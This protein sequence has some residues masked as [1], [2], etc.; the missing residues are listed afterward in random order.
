MR[1]VFAT[2]HVRPSAQA[3]PLAAGCLVAALPEET[4]RDA[5]LVDLFPSQSL[6]EMAEAVLDAA[7][8]LVA[9]PVYVWNRDRLLALAALLRRRQPA[10]RIIAGGP[11]AGAAPLALLAPGTIDLL[12]QGEAEDI[13]PQ[14]LTLS[15]DTAQPPPGVARFDGGQLQS[16]PAAP[17]PEV[18]KLNSPWLSGVLTPPADGGLLWETSRGCPF[19]CDFCFDSRGSNRVRPLPWE[20]LEAELALFVRARV[21]QIW[22]LDSTFNYPPERGKK[23]LRLLA[24]KAPHIHFH[25][26]AKADFLDRETAHLLGALSCS[27]QI[28]LQSAHP[29]VLRTIHRNLDPD[30]FRKNI[31]LL[32]AEGVTYGLDL[33]YGLPGDSL[34]GFGASL[35]FALEQRPNQIDIFP[36]AVLPGTILHRERERLGLD[37]QPAPPYEILAAPGFPADDLQQACLLA[38]VTDIFY[39]RGRAVGFF[40]PLQRGAGLGALALLEEFLRWLRADKALGEAAIRD[41]EAWLPRAI[42]DLHMEF[43]AHLLTQRERGHLIPAARDLIRYHYY[44]AET[45]LGPETLPVESELL[46]GRDLWTTPWRLNPAAHLVRFR[47]EIIDLLQVEDMD[48]E[49]FTRLFRP[50]GSAALFA[51]RGNEVYCES[52]EEDFAKLLDHSD[53]SRSPREI[54]AGSINRREGEEFVDFAVSEGILLPPEA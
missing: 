33:I 52:L 42:R 34:A 23:L 15:P 32:A 29:K 21:A 39:N 2:L 50:V 16:G 47:Y 43:T 40:V 27:V 19:A 38:A 28:G 53:G 22:V 30:D 14:V 44:Y 20:R 3:V 24:E 9:L 46:R 10:L 4:R 17:Q 49:Q 12:I 41:S 18:D 25:L 6:D 7:P 54:F 11:E 45:L 36:L 48:L 13:L 35:E 8:D 5:R 37:S 31:H 26:E 1:I 51:R